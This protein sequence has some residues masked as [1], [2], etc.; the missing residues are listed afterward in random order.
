MLFDLITNFWDALL[1]FAVPLICL[2][3]WMLF[4]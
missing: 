2:V 4:D 1:L 3:G